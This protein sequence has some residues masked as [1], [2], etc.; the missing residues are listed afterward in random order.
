MFFQNV[1]SVE[2]YG[3]EFSGVWKPA[4]FR[5]VA[6]FNLNLTYN[7]AEFQDG[8]STFA[9]AGNRLPDNAEWLAQAG[10]T[11]EPTPW[12]VANLSARY[13]SERFSNF[14]NSQEIGAY[15]VWNAYVD[16][17]D[18]GDLGPLKG[19]KLRLNVDNIFDED[20]LGTINTTINTPA[21]FRPGPD[22]TVQATITGSF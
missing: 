2:S 7:I 8:F 9:I 1:G 3:A 13:L 12:L 14:T 17:G 6:Y 15:T 16:L 22:R 21:T 11:V 5:D 19:V 18:G 4:V 10:V 20:Y